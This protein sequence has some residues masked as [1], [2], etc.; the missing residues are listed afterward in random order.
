MASRDLTNFRSVT[1]QVA[2]NKDQMVAVGAEM[3]QKIL[4]QRQEAKIV[5]GVSEAQL[6]LGRLENQYRIDYEGD[7]M[8]GLEKYKADR[9]KIFDKYKKNV[10]PLY[11]RQW[12]AEVQKIAT[13]NDATQQAWGLKQSRINTVDSVN[14][15]MK[16]NFRQAMN[17]GQSF[18][19]SDETQIEAFVNYGTA[20]DSLS[21][22]AE[23]N[24]G[25]ET[26]ENM[27]ETYEQDYLKSF[28][29]GVA[30]TN[31]HKA[32]ALLNDETVSDGFV[33]PDQL[34]KFKRSV[35]A[36]VK[37]YD[38]AQRKKAKANELAA[39]NSLL[40]E[41]GNM[42]YAEMQQRFSEFNIS[43]TA[44]A[45]YEDV[46][47]YTNT[48]RRLTGAEKA[49]GKNQF[50]GFMSQIVGQEDMTED[51]IQLLQDAVYG[52]MTK[53]VLTKNEGYGLLNNILEPVIKEQQER[54]DQF[55]TGTWNPFQENLG[56]D[57]L[58]EE[59]VKF[60][61]AEN[62]NTYKTGEKAGQVKG[63]DKNF[64]L[65]RNQNIMYS[66]YMETLS[67]EA[68]V[69]GTTIAG[70]SKLPFSKEKEVYNKALKA[71]KEAYIRSVY[72]D[73]ANQEE[74]PARI[75]TGDGRTVNTGLSKPKK[76]KV[77]ASYELMEDANGNFA[78]VYSDGRI[79][80]V[81]KRTLK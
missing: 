7:P 74:L 64:I 79:E 60:T 43:P 61:G 48:K 68:E 59:I 24:L 57:T 1:Q 65:N 76:E 26:A 58:N 69:N 12:D 19:L 28:V 30:E 46:N 29:S 33:D 34:V 66:A 70:L 53:G 55:E 73:L 31:P 38:V 71:S 80:E 18:G 23:K 47:G 40:N 21:E 9:Q 32:L 41:V 14:D 42:G 39:T 22:F 45:F 8:G 50:F 77:Q 11:G 67:K 6:E 17:D 51:D 5:Q 63:S 81:D 10:S 62:Y 16:N 36:R 54:A 3:A 4:G 20:M 49:D 44:Q 27:L 78:R 13:R 56:L 75:I 72:P 15:T 2:S 52:G 25:S 37:R 35:E